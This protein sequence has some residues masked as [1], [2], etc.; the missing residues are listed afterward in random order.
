MAQSKKNTEDVAVETTEKVVNI[1]FPL[2][3]DD[4]EL[5]LRYKTKAKIYNN[6]E[7][8]RQLFL[9][10]LEEVTKPATELAAA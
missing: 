5:F 9:Q 6:A 2:R 8:A 7:A 3:G 10:R 4:A 1:S